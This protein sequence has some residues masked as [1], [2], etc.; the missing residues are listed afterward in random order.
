M[1]RYISGPPI[2]GTSV[3][4]WSAR[5][6]RLYEQRPK[7]LGAVALLSN[8]TWLLAQ[9]TY[10]SNEPAVDSNGWVGAPE[11][12]LDFQD[13]FIPQSLR[14]DLKAITANKLSAKIKGEKWNLST[15]MGEL[16][17]TLK[18]FQKAL[19]EIVGLYRAVRRGDL[20]SIKRL[21]KRGRAYLRRRG[22][23]GAVKNGSGALA[24]RWLEFRY[25]ISPLVYDME[26]MLSYL[27][28]ASEHPFIRR[29]ASG[30]KAQWVH[31]T[32]GGEYH[33]DFV[34]SYIIQ[35]RGVAYFTVHPISEGFKQLGLINLAATLW[36]LTPLSFVADMFLPIGDRLARLDAMAG[37][38]LLGVTY[39]ESINGSSV[40]VEKTLAWSGS[41]YT[42]TT[43]SSSCK[44]TFYN[45]VP[46]PD[47]PWVPPTYSEHPTVR[48]TLDLT[49]LMRTLL[50]K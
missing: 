36:E 26:D 8:P 44:A 32:D 22:A 30:E 43:G 31:K 2:P 24:R 15:F 35:G 1:Q 17:A 7:P 20:R 45:R 47:L 48:Q 27:Y 49:A 33:M 37:V 5:I 23:F 34:H 39:S 28:K 14:S 12:T 38:S 42:M 13:T 29:A 21:A 50:F 6:E 10:T 25:A 40:G 18:Y 3:P 41:N 4:Y 9:R 16:P 19:S 11:F 46:S